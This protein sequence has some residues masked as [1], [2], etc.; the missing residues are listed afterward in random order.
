[1]SGFV[2]P[3]SS[4]GIVVDVSGLTKSYKFY[5]SRPGF[6]GS[7]RDLFGRRHGE[8]LAVDGLDLRVEAGEFVGLLGRNGAGKTTLLKMLAGLLHPTS[9]TARVL[10]QEPRRRGFEFLSRIALVLGNKSMLWWDISTLDNLGLYR[11]LYD[12]PTRQFDQDL[13]ELAALLAVS[14]QLDVPVRKLSLGQRMKCELLMAL[15]HRPEVLFLDEPAIGLDVVSKAAIR[16]SLRRLNSERGTTILLT[17][18]DMDDVT[19]LC[20]RILL[21][22]QGRLRFS[23]PPE[24]LV[25]QMQPRKYVVCSYSRPLADPVRLPTG[26]ELIGRDATGTRWE[27]RADRAAIPGLLESVGQ[28]G[29]L[30]DVEIRDPDLDEAMLQILQEPMAGAGS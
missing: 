14:D 26:A 4:S 8:R 2:V 15:I 17:S 28:W 11:A 20:R 5:R 23:G 3:G 13:A 7:V 1:M 24:A 25:R 6:R 29:E 30:V 10:G 27:L 12:L 9:G 18:H 21:I 22:D 16:S 19:E